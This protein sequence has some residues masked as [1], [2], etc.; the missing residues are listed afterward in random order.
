[1]R[2]KKD[3]L[4]KLQEDVKNM[5][6]NKMVSLSN[7]S[8]PY[9]RVEKKLGV[10]RKTLDFLA[11][12]QIKYQIITKSDLVTRDIDIFKESRCC[13]AVTIT[14]LNKEVAEK[15]EPNASSPTERVKALK[16]LHQNNILITLRIDPII[17]FINDT[18][19][20]SLINK[21][22]FVDHVTAST[23]KPRRDSWK[24][25]SKVFPDIAEK[26]REHY[27][28]KGEK[29]GN[30][31]YLPKNMRFKLLSKVKQAAENEGIS[32]GSCRENFYSSHSCDGSHLIS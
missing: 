32:F 18:E 22:S 28:I 1:V 3:F 27:F 23:F 4:K 15:L 16:K 14:T 30:S 12:N 20:E 13:V 17:P 29:R 31:W 21:L 2:T 10:T 26:L 9:P 19:T 24:R 5:D 25:F 6:K 7:S 8:D 11:R